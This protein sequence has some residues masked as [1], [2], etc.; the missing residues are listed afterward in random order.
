MM[1]D[2]QDQTTGSHVSA[3]ERALK[4]V[5]SIL[6]TEPQGS[7]LR[8]SV[9]GGG[10]SGFKYVFEIDTAVAADDIVLGHAPGLIAIDPVSAGYMKGSEIDFVSDLMGQ[11]F[12]VENPLAKASCGCGTSFTL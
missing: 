8:V 5:A 7:L 10:C 11:S 4:R 6:A 1:Q 12:R 2:V 3:T 9:S